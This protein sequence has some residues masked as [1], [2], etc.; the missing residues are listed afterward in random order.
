MNRGISDSEQPQ[1]DSLASSLSILIKDKQLNTASCLKEVALC[2]VDVSIKLQ[3]INLVFS[4]RKG[5]SQA[6]TSVLSG[7]LY[8]FITL[9]IWS[10]KNIMKYIF[11]IQFH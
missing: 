4:G 9:N 8:S 10:N 6:E 5:L 1:C 2:I 7:T 11:P 3:E